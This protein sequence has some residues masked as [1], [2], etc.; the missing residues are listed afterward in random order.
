MAHYDSRSCS[1]GG[2]P[3]E[4]GETTL[5]AIIMDGP[6]HK[7]GAV[8]DLRRIKNA[9]GVARA[10]MNFTKH[11]FLVGDSATQ[12]AV[13]M[14]FQEETLQTD[15]SVDMWKS[16]RAKQCQP[17]FW[18]VPKCL[19]TYRCFCLLFLLYCRMYCRIRRLLVGRT[20]LSQISKIARE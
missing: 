3:D 2:S 7:M 6:G 8:G 16:W 11:S 9:I 15:T 5:D 4:S 14:G 13:S 10:V 1:F 17:N 12:F 19:V 20:D 18:Q